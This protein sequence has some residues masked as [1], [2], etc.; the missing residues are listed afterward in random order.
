M[1]LK[2]RMD[3]LERSLNPNPEDMLTVILDLRG[4]A[5]RGAPAGPS[6]LL[7]SEATWLPT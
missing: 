1:G 6:L 3:R 5:D 7:R 4:L 2:Q